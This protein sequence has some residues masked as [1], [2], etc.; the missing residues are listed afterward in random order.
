VFV[1]YNNIENF[2]IPV[3]RA[4][5]RGSVAELRATGVIPKDESKVENFFIPIAGAVAKGTLFGLRAAGLIQKKKSPVEEVLSWP[6][7]QLVSAVK[8]IFP[9]RGSRG[10]RCD[11]PNTPILVNKNY[12]NLFNQPSNR[13]CCISGDGDDP[14]YAHECPSSRIILH[15]KYCPDTSRPCCVRDY[16]SVPQSMT[17]STETP[18]NYISAYVSPSS[19]GISELYIFRNDKYYRYSITSTWRLSEPD[20]GYPKLISG[21]YGSVSN[22]K[23]IFYRYRAGITNDEGDYVPV[24]NKDKYNY[25]FT[26]DGYYKYNPSRPSLSSKLPLRNFKIDEG[27]YPRAIVQVN[28]KDIYFF[29]D[30]HYYIYSNKDVPNFSREIIKGSISQLLSHTRIRNKYQTIGGWNPDNIKVDAAFKHPDG[31]IYILTRD[32]RRDDPNDI[33]YYRYRIINKYIW[34]LQSNYPRNFQLPAEVL[35]TTMSPITT[36]TMSPVTTTTMSPVTTTTMSP[37]RRAAVEGRAAMRARSQR[38]WRNR[39]K[40]ATTM[41]PARRAVVKGNASRDFNRRLNQMRPTATWPAWTKWGE[42]GGVVAEV[43]P[44]TISP[45]TTTMS[46]TTAAATVAVPWWMKWRQ[47]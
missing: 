31:T 28:D 34:E 14:P 1:F 33:T 23:S 8:N 15:S 6:E 42:R 22:I 38:Q 17:L 32:A 20:S 10:Y 35:P 40:A 25:I 47:R 4:I 41:S 3:A 16:T 44:T 9:R 37:A 29:S 7:D 46:P 19:S 43:L 26:N 18:N 27:T 11:N 30:T 45:I 36:T 13:P 2:F 24:D 21:T 39:N 12:C 5:E